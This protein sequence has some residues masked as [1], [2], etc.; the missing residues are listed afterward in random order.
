M[1]FG[2]MVE[3]TGYYMLD[4]TVANVEISGLRIFNRSYKKRRKI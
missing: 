2:I 4:K 3:D 1:G